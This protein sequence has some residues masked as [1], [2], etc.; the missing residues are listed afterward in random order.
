MGASC[1]G[2]RGSLGL[3]EANND[4]RRARCWRAPT[5]AVNDGHD[6]CGVM[7]SAS[8][9]AT[10]DAVYRCLH[11]VKR[12]CR[13]CHAH[14]VMLA[15][16]D[17]ESGHSRHATLSTNPKPPGPH[18]HCEQDGIAP[19]RCGMPNRFCQLYASHQCDCLFAVCTVLRVPDFAIGDIDACPQQAAHFRLHSIGFA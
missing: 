6:D 16:A 5:D 3:V 17:H 18:L 4:G 1:D 12:V 15:P 14:V 11:I 8:V 13:F 2:R 9:Y 10:E 7:S 19:R